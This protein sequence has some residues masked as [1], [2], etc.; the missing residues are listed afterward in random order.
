M[1]PAAPNT[2]MFSRSLNAEKLPAAPDIAASRRSVS[3]SAG[4][5]LAKQRSTIRA[6]G[7]STRASSSV[8]AVIGQSSTLRLASPVTVAIEREAIGS[9]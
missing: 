6:P 1:P 3:V 9:A 4:S 2:A 7:A 8:T 5:G